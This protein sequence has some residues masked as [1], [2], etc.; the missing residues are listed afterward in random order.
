MGGVLDADGALVERMSVADAEAL[1]ASGVAH[2]G[3][4]AKLR[5]A[6]GAVL[7]G[8]GEVRIAAGSEADVL[9]RLLAGEPLGTAFVAR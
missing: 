1:I 8:A 7:G 3:M 4:E 9:P 2:G 5:A 6:S